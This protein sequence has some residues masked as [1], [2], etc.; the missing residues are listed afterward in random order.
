MGKQK[1]K[2]QPE[3]P[4]SVNSVDWDARVLELVT[5][6]VLPITVLPLALCLV[7]MVNAFGSSLVGAPNQARTLLDVPHFRSS[8]AGSLI[9]FF[10]RVGS[11]IGLA[12][13]LVIYYVFQHS[14]VP[15]SGRD[16]LGPTIAIA[17]NATFI[18]ISMVIAL[19]DRDRSA[20]RLR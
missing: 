20:R 3:R 12:L 14:T 19:V 8:I 16:T 10:Q 15:W 11:A 9:Q 1:Q 13:A 5:K 2:R 17:V 6:G 18:A 7:L 4:V